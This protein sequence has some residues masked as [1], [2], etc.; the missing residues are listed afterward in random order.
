VEFQA[1]LEHMK[2]Q[3]KLKKVNNSQKFTVVSKL[4]A[5]LRAKGFNL[6]VTI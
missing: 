1:G 3:L 5:S 4:R 2:K 6:L